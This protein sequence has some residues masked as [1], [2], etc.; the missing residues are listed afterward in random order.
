MQK[1]LVLVTL[2]A[3]GWLAPPLEILPS[4]LSRDVGNAGLNQCSAFP[5]A[6]V[7]MLLR[8]DATRWLD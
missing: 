4:P 3:T 2:A 1:H 5:N 8:A 7:V 6:P